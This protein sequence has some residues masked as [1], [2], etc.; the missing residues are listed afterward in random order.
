MAGRIK[1]V[2]LR[3]LV[4]WYERDR[5]RAALLDALERVPPDL[6]A[7]F[8]LERE[9]LGVLAATWY[10]A[11]L[12]HALLDAMVHGLDPEARRR[13]AYD[14]SVAAMRATLGGVHRAVLRIVGSPEL[15]AKFGQR[16]WRTYFEDGIA[17]SRRVD[18]H[19]HRLAF[20]QWHSHH[21]VLCDMVTASDLVVFP[22]MG[23]HGVTVEQLS[24][25]DR[26]DS[27]CAHF[28][29]WT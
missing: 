22:A 3:E 17:D 7:R 24:C 18:A 9:A 25:V 4:A 1:G 15:H 2:A 20:R 21:P 27:E 14:G 19:T 16:M 10:E 6:R 23:L 11:R 26:G 12:V 5:G 28:I 13:L 8:D 29:R